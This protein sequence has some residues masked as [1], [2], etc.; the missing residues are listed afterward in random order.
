MGT[1]KNE[2]IMVVYAMLVYNMVY[3][4]MKHKLETN[5]LR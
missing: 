4:Y 3:T 2:L 5:A 1:S